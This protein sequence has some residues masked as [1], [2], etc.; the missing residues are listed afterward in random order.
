MQ[1]D[2]VIN[3]MKRFALSILIASAATFSAKSQDIIT[4]VDGSD[5]IAVVLN[6]DSTGVHFKYYADPEGQT[7]MLSENAILMI[8]YA[9][10]QAGIFPEGYKVLEELARK[11]QEAL[12]QQQAQKQK[13]KCCLCCR[14]RRNR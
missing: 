4:C 11:E 10:G 3:E 7:Y 12:E 2:S 9:N 14:K 5:I 1:A 8:R 13:R 6:I